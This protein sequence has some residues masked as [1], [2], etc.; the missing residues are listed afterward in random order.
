MA[1]RIW[2]Y[3][4]HRGIIDPVDDLRSTNPPINPELLDAL[5]DDFAA[6]NFDSRRLMRLIVTSQTY[7]RSSQANKSNAHDD[8]NFSRFVPR[9]VSAESL[10]DCLVQVTGMPESF[11]GTRRGSPPGNCRTQTSKANS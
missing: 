1:N 3:F 6:N 11:P 10:L 7:Q 2:S 4:F 8:A 9:R 5:T